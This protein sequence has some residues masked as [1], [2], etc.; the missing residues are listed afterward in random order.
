MKKNTAQPGDKEK[1]NAGPKP[2]F[3]PAA[4]IERHL[5]L[6]Y[7]D[8]VYTQKTLKRHVRVIHARAVKF[9]LE[10]DLDSMVIAEDLFDDWEDNEEGLT[11]K[12]AR[13]RKVDRF[14]NLTYSEEEYGLA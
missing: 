2:K 6:G 9:Y 11:V 7:P 10:R 5:L 8:T 4:V 1:E 3:R 14:P 12:E 13:K